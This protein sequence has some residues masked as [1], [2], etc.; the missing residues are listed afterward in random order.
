M[1]LSNNAYIALRKK[2]WS[3]REENFSLKSV[4]LETLFEVAA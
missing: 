3:R 2:E 4:R 1:N